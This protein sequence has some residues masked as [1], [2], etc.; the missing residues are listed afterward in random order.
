M[1]DY[2]QH[3]Q[4]TSK[5]GLAWGLSVALVLHLLAFYAIQS[6]L[7]HRFVKII[8]APVEAQLIEEVKPNIPPPPPPP[9][10]PEKLPS[11]KSALPDYVPAVEVPQNAAPLANAITQF[12]STPKPPS[13][14]ELPVSVQAPPPIVRTSAVINASQSCE[15]PIYPSASRRLQESGTVQLRFHIGV[16]GKVLES[17]VEKSSGY[18]RLDEAARTALSKCQFKPA[19]VD[20]RPEASWSSLRY[21]WKI[22]E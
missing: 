12:S 1:I 5:R 8:Q 14:P 19:T 21:V 18:K 3:Q 6:G 2:A 4:S 20:G 9:P 11:Q 7:A 16:D 17:E 10:P 15:T 22:E 13:P